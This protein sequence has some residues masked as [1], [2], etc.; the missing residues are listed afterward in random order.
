MVKLSASRVKTLFNCGIIYY[1]QYVRKIPQGPN[2]S[3][4]ARGSVCHYILECLLRKDRKEK[5]EKILTIGDPWVIPSV[6][7]MA[8]I[9]ARKLEVAD[10][11]NFEMIRKFILV[12]LQT[13]FYCKGHI[14]LEAEREFDIKTDSYHIGGFV[15]K[16]SL[17]SDKVKIIDYKSSK[18]KF[19]G[20][21]YSF[22]LQNYFYVLAEKKRLEEEGLDLP[23]ELEFQFLKFAKE[24][25][26]KAPHITDDE[27][28]GFEVWL[29]EV[30]KFIDNLTY[31]EAKSL[32]AKGS[33]DRQWLCG[34]SPEN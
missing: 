7:R 17:H 32:A 4:A 23:I 25:I 28:K 30:T 8:E 26:Q 22:N 34:K 29:G 21:D 31:S 6:K 12:A 3:G 15:D 20:K 10:D 13:D 24:P 9:H 2:N 1:N 16:R 5:V 33:Y 27:L 14:E 19:T 11:V 18:S